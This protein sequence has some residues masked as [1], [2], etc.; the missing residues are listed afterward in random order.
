MK[1]FGIEPGIELG[2]MIKE[3]ETENFIKELKKL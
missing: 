1:K 2:K 3:M